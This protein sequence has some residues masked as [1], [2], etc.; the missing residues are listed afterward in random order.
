MTVARRAT[1][2]QDKFRNVFACDV[3]PIV[4]RGV[5][6]AIKVGKAPGGVY[7][8]ADLFADSEFKGRLAVGSM[9][10]RPKEVRDRLRCLAK[11]KVDAWAVA[12]SLAKS[13]GTERRN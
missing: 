8:H 12:G 3:P 6:I 13:P 5:S 2:R 1:R 4:Y 9:R 11:S 10:R 7:G